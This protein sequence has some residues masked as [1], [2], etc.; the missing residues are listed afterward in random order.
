VTR[1][2]ALDP[3]RSKCGLVITDPS[4]SWIE[5]ALVAAPEIC[6]E[7][8][9]HWQQQKA[10]GEVLLGDGTG[11][12]QWQ[13]WLQQVRLPHQV[14]QEHGTTLAARERYWELEPARSWRRL[15]PQGMR[16]P[17]RDYDDVVAQIL[18]ERSLGR[19][20]RRP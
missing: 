3:G 17:P 15:I 11:S 2:A 20:L 19:R 18:L 6:R 9:Q 13:Q 5:E 8:L 12:P 14:V 4:R 7:Q 16:L 1:I 10:L